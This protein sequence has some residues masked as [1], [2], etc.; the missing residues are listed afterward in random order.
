MTSGL[1]LEKTI[2]ITPLESCPKAYLKNKKRKD[3]FEIIWLKDE[4]PLHFMEGDTPKTK[5]EWM[6]LIPPNRNYPLNKLGK[7]GI[8]IAF[9]KGVLDYEVKEF[10]LDV[11]KLFTRQSNFSTLL[12]EGELATTLDNIYSILIDE[13]GKNNNNFLLLR[14]LLKAFLLKLIYHQEHAFTSQDFN[15]KRIYQFLLLLEHHYK[16]EKN[17]EFYAEK[18]NLTSK[19]LNQI[20]KQK[21]NRT[22]RQF[23]HERLIMEAKHKLIISEHTIKEISIQLGID[24]RSYF[25]R[26]FKK[27][28]GQTPEGFQKQAKARIS[29]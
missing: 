25:S 13:Y 24:D 3:F 2:F 22:I 12:I 7:K 16:E 23:I 5:S 8:L 6:Y 4:M 29:P 19:R 15:E 10:S 20:L 14:T 27:M 26:F 18:L 1:R 28:T 21:T 17:V 9:N 11:F